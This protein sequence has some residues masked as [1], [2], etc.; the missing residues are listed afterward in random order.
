MVSRMRCMGIYEMAFFKHLANCILIMSCP[1]IFVSFHMV[2]CWFW[3]VRNHKV[4]RNYLLFTPKGLPNLPLAMTFTH[5][6]PWYSLN[7]RK[8]GP[9]PSYKWRDMGRLEM[10]ENK[11]GNWGYFTPISGV[12]GPYWKNLVTLR[13]IT[14]PPQRLRA[15]ISPWTSVR[16]AT[17]PISVSFRSPEGFK[18]R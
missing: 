2:G 10:A 14:K 5:G 12:M 6:I 8:M 13:H 3:S 9:E 7:S 18:G 4:N 15:K 11:W 16:G 1:Q 17:G